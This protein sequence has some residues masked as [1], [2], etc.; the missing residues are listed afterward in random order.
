MSQKHV[1]KYMV[2]FAAQIRRT[3][4]HRGKHCND[5]VVE[6]L[7]PAPLC[8]VGPMSYVLVGLLIHKQRHRIGQ[9]MRFRCDFFELFQLLFGGQNKR[10]GRKY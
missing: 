8:T 6:A 9:L 2:W 7:Q 10:D 1:A 5:S 4:W 3:Q